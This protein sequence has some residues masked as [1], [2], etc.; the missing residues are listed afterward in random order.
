MT[1]QV[2]AAALVDVLLTEAADER[3]WIIAIA[4]APGAGKSTLSEHLKRRLDTA[5]PGCADVLMMDGFHFDDLVLNA[6]GHRLRKGAPHTFDVDGFRVALERLRQDDGRDVA[7]PVFDRSIE[8]ARAGARILAP[9]ARI[10]IAEGNYLLL[11]EP[12]WRD[13]APLFDLTVM[14]QASEGELATRLTARWQGFDYPSEA[15]KA[16]L[17][18][19]D[20]PNVRLV[21]AKSRAADM[22]VRSAEDSQ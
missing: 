20:L 13:L 22:V 17:E 10:I 7:V 8:I 19:N 14:M 2:T 4:G 18:E 12:G 15:F 11:D 9:S 1:Q 3:R 21:I 5:R 16:K 6:R